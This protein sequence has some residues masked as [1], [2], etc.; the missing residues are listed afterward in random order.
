MR[1][2]LRAD[3]RA[4]AR[5]SSRCAASAPISASRRCRSTSTS[6]ARTRSS[7][8]CASCC[9]HEFA[10]TLAARRPAVDWRERPRPLR[11]RLPGARPGAPGGLRAARPRGRA[12]LRRGPRASP[13]PASQRLIDA[14]LDRRDRD[15]T[16]SAPSCASSSGSA[17]STRPARTPRADCRSELDGPRPPPA[18]GGRADALARRRD[19]RRALRVRPRGH[20]GRASARSSPGTDGAERRRPRVAGPPGLPRPAAAVTPGRRW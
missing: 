3:R 18:P 16:P 1:A 13:R 14:G 4:R 9:W 15:P 19:R 17:S 20:P 11:P 5:R 12:R 2:A 6:R 8:G 7:T 10:A